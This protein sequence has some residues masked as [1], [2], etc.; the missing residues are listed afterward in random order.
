MLQ[1]SYLNFI[2]FVKIEQKKTLKAKLC[3]VNFNRMKTES[4]NRI[5]A[6]KLKQEALKLVYIIK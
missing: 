1:I 4:T 3:L 6:T 2:S 5:N